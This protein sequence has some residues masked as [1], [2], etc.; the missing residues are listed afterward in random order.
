LRVFVT[1]I[2]INFGRLDHP[3]GDQHAFEKAVRVGFEE[4]SVFK[5]AGFALVGIDRN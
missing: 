2:D 4:M 1:E 3:S 5:G